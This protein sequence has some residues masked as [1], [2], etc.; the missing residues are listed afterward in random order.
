MNVSR[1]SDAL[2]AQ[3]DARN[4]FGSLL[5]G[6][7][8]VSLLVGGVG[9]A[10]TMIISVLERRQEIGLRRALGARR[11]QILLQFLTEAVAL[12]ALGGFAGAALGVASTVVYASLQG[13]PAVL[14]ATAIA[15][16]VVSSMAIGA[17][18]GLYPA[19]RAGRLPPTEALNTI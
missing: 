16:G 14:P 1:P 12:S 13:W 19:R 7:G 6:L 8:S 5:I 15:A 18:A 11:R 2:T 10:N 17:A 3:L 9:V 4:T